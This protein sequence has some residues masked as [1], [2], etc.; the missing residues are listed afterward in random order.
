MA[1]FVPV[2]TALFAFAPVATAATPER[3][4]G[5]EID[6]VQ[7]FVPNANI[8]KPKLTGRLWQSGPLRGDL[9][10]GAYIR[11]HIKH[12]VVYTIDEYML[13]AGY[14]QYWWRGLH[15]EALIDGGL[16]WGTNRF[17]QKFYRTPT[18]FLDASV[19]YRFSFENIGLY[20]APQAGVIAS[21][22]ISSIGPRNGKP[23]WFLQGNLLVGY[24]F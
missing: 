12:D 5:V 19:G 3:P 23:D 7:P 11:P 24:A 17:D 2:L 4:L 21:L 6:L 20:V 14:R 13:V 10:L 22:G 9:V 16:A 8:I 18:L 1:R 15:A